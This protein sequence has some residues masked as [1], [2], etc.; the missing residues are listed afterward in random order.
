MAI[1]LHQQHLPSWGVGG[2]KDDFL[3]LSGGLLEGVLLLL[4]R[5]ARE[6]FHCG[7]YFPMVANPFPPGSPTM[8]TPTT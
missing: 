7:K 5:G 2:G 4:R 6:V 8:A 1:V 3:G